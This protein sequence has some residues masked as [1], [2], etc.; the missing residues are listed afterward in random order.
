MVN[1]LGNSFK[2]LISNE[3]FNVFKYLVYMFFFILAKFLH[4]FLKLF[5]F[6]FQFRFIL[7]KKIDRILKI[8]VNK[9]KEKILNILNIK[10]F[11]FV[12]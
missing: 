8:C 12:D 9:F 3:N 10:F 5:K 6:F 2:G 11:A 4:I 1:M 7:Y